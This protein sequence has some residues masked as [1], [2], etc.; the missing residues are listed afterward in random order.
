LIPLIEF[1]VVGLSSTFVSD[2]IMVFIAAR[3]GR[4]NGVDLHFSHASESIYGALTINEKS[5]N[6]LSEV[7]I[8][9]N[10][11]RY[12]LSDEAIAA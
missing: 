7:Y 4:R 11:D 3:R 12:L 8:C 10:S 6:K 5:M 9:S 1:H 2:L